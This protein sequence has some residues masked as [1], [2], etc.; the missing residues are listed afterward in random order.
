MTDMSKSKQTVKET[1]E[2]I[3]Y[4]LRGAIGS[5]WSGGRLFIGM[6]AFLLASLAFSY[7]YLRAANNGLLSIT[8][9]SNSSRHLASS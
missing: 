3:E 4:E 1:P 5:I 7:F 9:K 6:Y 8:T 2:E